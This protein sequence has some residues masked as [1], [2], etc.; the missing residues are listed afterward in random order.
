LTVEAEAVG[1]DPA[2]PRDA[3]QVEKRFLLGGGL[4]QPKM[5]YAGLLLHD[6]RRSAVRNPVRSQVP[7]KV[8]MSISGHKARAV[9]DRYNIVS[10]ND[11][12]KAGR[13]LEVYFEDGE[14]VHRNAAT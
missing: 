11:L 3:Q 4:G 13:Q 9:F 7:E 14:R 6:L 2:A 5:V 8:A 12:A 1:K 10:E